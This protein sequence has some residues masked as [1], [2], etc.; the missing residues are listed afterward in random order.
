MSEIFYYQKLCSAH[1]FVLEMWVPL[2]E[3]IKRLEQPDRR[4]TS[5]QGQESH[6]YSVTLQPNFLFFPLLPR[7]Q[8]FLP[9]FQRQNA[10]PM[11]ME[12]E[13]STGFGQSFILFFI[14]NAWLP[15]ALALVIFSIQAEF[16]L[17]WWLTIEGLWTIFYMK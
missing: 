2:S 17:W 12:G 4:L 10:H 1:S 3:D 6:L 11:N 8:L 9:N 16:S 13:R 5:K 14:T 15:T 7:P